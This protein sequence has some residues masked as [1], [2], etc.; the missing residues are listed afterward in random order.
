M[1]WSY[2]ARCKARERFWTPVMDQCN[3][4]L[5]IAQSEGNFDDVYNN[6]SDYIDSSIFGNRWNS[7][8]F[9]N[10]VRMVLRQKS[11]YFKLAA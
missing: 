8:V 11:E 6:T 2:I 4:L 7:P 3:I 1:S 9:R 5:Q 10:A